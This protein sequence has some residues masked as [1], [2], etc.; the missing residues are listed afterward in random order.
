MTLPPTI[1]P[2]ADVSPEAHLGAGVRVWQQAQVRAGA[3]VGDGCNIGKGAYVGT[4][5][6]IG[7]N[8]KIHNYA[9]VH[10]GVTIE[11]GVFVGPHVCFAND[12]YPRAV[13][14]DGRLKTG[15]DWDLAGSHVEYGA[16]LGARSVILPGV[17]VGRFALVGAGSVVTKDVPAYGLVRGNPARLVGHVCA[18]GRPTEDTRGEAYACADCRGDT[19]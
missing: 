8:C 3:S 19:P 14:P 15:S 9:L 17:R 12:R 11:D 5:V 6:R 4:D 13:T 2:S 7:A 10:E 1:H 16:S 18:C